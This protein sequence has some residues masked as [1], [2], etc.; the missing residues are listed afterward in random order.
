MA[1]NVL[2]RVFKYNSKELKDFNYKASP[3]SILNYYTDEFP[4]LVGA[5]ISGP[6]IENGKAVYVFEKSLGTKG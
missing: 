4:E 1:I 2:E 5:T 6:T 3:E